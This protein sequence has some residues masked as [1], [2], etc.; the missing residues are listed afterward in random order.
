MNKGI[1]LIVLVVTILVIVILTGAVIL[2]ITSS[3][4]ILSVNE[5]SFKRNTDTYH[6][7]LLTILA[8]NYLDENNFNPNGFDAC[9]WDGNGD[10]SG[11][12]KEYITSMS[13]KDGSKFKIE[14]GKLIYIGAD[15]N[16]KHWCDDLG[17][18]NNG[19]IPLG[20]NVIA[21]QNTTFNGLNASYSNPIIPK[22]FK[23]VNI[24]A[25]WGVDYN[26]GLV[27]EDAS[28]NQFVWIPVDNV[29]IAYAK[30]FTYP[31]CYSATSTNTLDDTLPLGVT[32]ELDQ[33]NKYGGFYISRFEAGKENT[34]TLVSKAGSNVWNKIIYSDAKSKAESMYTSSNLKSGLV[35]GTQ[36][37]T[38]MNFFSYNGINV[39]D[40]R[41]WGN[42]NNSLAPANLSTY[43]SLMT[44]GNNE[45][46][47]VCNIYDLAG[48]AFEWT[49]ECY[50]V[51]R[52]FRGGSYNSSGSS[53][54][55]SYRDYGVGP[56]YAYDEVSFR[57]VLY[58]I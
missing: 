49:N 4:S 6:S 18:E 46:W 51:Y 34:S 8:N 36:W 23:A 53:K 10:G 33:I 1:S 35:T 37:D 22:D 50:G 38:M 15:V 54:P 47:K 19:F 24:D 58:V 11:T 32:S 57:V 9:C 16:E 56:G 28:G 41:T 44:C 55:V 31:K 5:A 13:P 29:N 52:I 20:V 39:N 48:N 17:I 30:N 26:K 45:N 2:N 21:S 25:V 43:G 12:I 3:N 42:Y 14:D 7:Q 27:I 40:S